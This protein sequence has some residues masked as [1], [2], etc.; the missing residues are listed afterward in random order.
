VTFPLHHLNTHPMDLLLYWPQ[1]FLEDGFQAFLDTIVWFH[2]LFIIIAHRISE[3]FI[4]ASL[5]VLNFIWE[6]FV[7]W[8]EEVPHY[9]TTI[10]EI[11]CDLTSHPN[12]E[13][14]A[15]AGPIFTLAIYNWMVVTFNFWK[16]IAQLVLVLAIAL[17]CALCLLL[18]L[19]YILYGLLIILF[20][21]FIVHVNLDVGPLI[22]FYCAVFVAWCEFRR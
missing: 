16:L 19:G 8:C 21:L 10:S 7:R 4:W 13:F 6:D 20:S 12:S 3:V 1:W 5:L 15:E 22:A 2:T 9:T 14:R 18:V 11:L 17:P